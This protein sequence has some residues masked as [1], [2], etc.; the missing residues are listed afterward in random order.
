MSSILDKVKAYMKNSV[1][2]DFDFS[3]SIFCGCSKFGGKPDV[4]DDF[5]WESYNGKPLSFI[6]QINLAEAAQ[7]DKDSLLP[8]EGLLSFFYELESMEWGYDPQTSNCAKIYWFSP[9][10]KLSPAEFPEVLD[11]EFRLPEAKITMNSCMYYPDPLDEDFLTEEESDEYSDAYDDVY[12]ELPE[13]LSKLLG[14]PNYIQGYIPLECEL[15]SRGI[16]TGQGYPELTQNMKEAAKE[17]VLL[18]QLDSFDC[19][20]CTLMFGDDGRIYWFIRKED[21]AAGNF[22][23]A[24][25]ILQCY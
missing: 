7:F 5:I 16:Y 12:D 9:D 19:S 2:L 1:D 18:F 10:K 6:A 20:E 21:L 23:K 22:D 24:Q 8:K 11:D 25:L 15:V 14:Y 13:K 4:P 17:W 3:G